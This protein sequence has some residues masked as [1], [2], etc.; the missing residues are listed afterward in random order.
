MFD[1]HPF[2]LRNWSTEYYTLISPEN[3]S[4]L[5]Y[6]E[7]PPDLEIEHDAN[8]NFEGSDVDE[9]ESPVP[10]NV[11]SDETQNPVAQNTTSE[12]GDSLPGEEQPPTA[13]EGRQ[14]NSQCISAEVLQSNAAE[15]DSSDPLQST[16][17][18]SEK[19]EQTLEKSLSNTME[20]G[21]TAQAQTE[22]K[23]VAEEGPVDHRPD[24]QQNQYGVIF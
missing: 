23:A 2:C 17:K 6:I 21:A 11:C 8:D 12:K 24:H 7:L 13:E 10:E 22:A 9:K 15:K 18:E 20:K 4:V 1:P 14:E 19:E 3:E 5:P 16:K